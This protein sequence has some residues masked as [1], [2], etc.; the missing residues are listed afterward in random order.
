VQKLFQQKCIFF[1]SKC[2]FTVENCFHYLLWVIL[3]G[4]NAKDKHLIC[5]SKNYS[6]QGIIQ[7]NEITNAL[8]NQLRM[9]PVLHSSIRDTFGSAFSACKLLEIVNSTECYTGTRR[10]CQNVCCR[11]NRWYTPIYRTARHLSR[12]LQ[13]ET[14]VYLY[15]TSRLRRFTSKLTLIY[16]DISF[17]L[18]FLLG[19][20]GFMFFILYFFLQVHVF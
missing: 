13:E 7:R 6:F 3:T 8:L 10:V 20:R 14:L 2:V 15:I 17:C 5:V 9:G 11:I 19:V 1:F 4:C 16:S 18:K 12:K